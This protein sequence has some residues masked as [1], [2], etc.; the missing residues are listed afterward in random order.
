[1]VRAGVLI[2]FWHGCR[3][4]TILI[5][6]IDAFPLA[7]LVRPTCWVWAQRGPAVRER[8]GNVGQRDHSI[9]FTS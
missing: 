2:E 3:T 8:W 1:M 7:G 9:Y 6:D 5:L 4:N